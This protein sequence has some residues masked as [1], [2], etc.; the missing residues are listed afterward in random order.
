MPTSSCLI[1]GISNL[2]SELVSSGA[3]KLQKGKNKTET[4]RRKE[5]K[6]Q[7]E[8]NELLKKQTDAH[9]GKTE[10]LG[11]K[12]SLYNGKMNLSAV[13]SDDSSRSGLSEE[14]H[15]PVPESVFY[16]SDGT[17]SRKK[18]KLDAPSPAARSGMC[19]TIQFVILCILQPFAVV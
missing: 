4:E 7:R 19:M 14:H 18:R 15:R 11:D 17:D 5:K 16:L 10:K 12:K 2:C 3:L 8:K 6:R 13:L 9:H 1:L